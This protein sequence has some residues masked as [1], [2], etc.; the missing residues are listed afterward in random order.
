M[1]FLDENMPIEYFENYEYIQHI[2]CS[3]NWLIIVNKAASERM[4]AVQNPKYPDDKIKHDFNKDVFIVANPNTHNSEIVYSVYTDNE[5]FEEQ[6]ILMHHKFYAFPLYGEELY[7]NYKLSLPSKI[8]ELISEDKLFLVRGGVLSFDNDT[9]KMTITEDERYKCTFPCNIEVKESINI[10]DFP[11]FDPDTG[12]CN[13]RKSISLHPHIK[14]IPYR[15]YHKTKELVSTNSDYFTIKKQDNEECEEEKIL[16]NDKKDKEPLLV[17]S[18]PRPK[19]KRVGFEN[20]VIYN[21]EKD[22][23]VY[24]REGIMVID[25]LNTNTLP[26][27]VICFNTSPDDNRYSGD[28]QFRVS[29]ISAILIDKLP[30]DKYDL[31]FHQDAGEPISLLIQACDKLYITVLVNYVIIDVVPYTDDDGNELSS[32]YKSITKYL[33]KS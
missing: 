14:Y 10:Y 11:I 30:D 18:E 26:N 3:H 25:K 5:I 2:C 15:Y 16:D 24:E 29:D 21:Q 12:K 20:I 1:L 31:L 4:I 33:I 13:V 23:N 7:L 28:Y 32:S 8:M 27:N 9:N 17:I 6:D 19:S 22:L